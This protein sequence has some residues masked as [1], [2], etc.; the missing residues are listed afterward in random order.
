MQVGN[1]QGGGNGKSFSWRQ[2]SQS[3]SLKRLEDILLDMVGRCI[4]VYYLIRD[5]SRMYACNLLP[6]SLFGRKRRFA[7]HEDLQE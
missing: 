2:N 6:P 5:S 7:L 1:H 4:L 3:F